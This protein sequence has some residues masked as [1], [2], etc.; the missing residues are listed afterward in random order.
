M[1]KSPKAVDRLDINFCTAEH[2]QRRLALEKRRA[3]RIN[4]NFSIILLDLPEPAN[5]NG[6]LG[7]LAKLICQEIRETDSV[8][9]HPQGALFILLPDT[10]HIGASCVWERLQI[11]L[12]AR[13]DHQNNGHG[14]NVFS[15]E[16]LCY[17]EKF[18]EDKLSPA[19]FA[20]SLQAEKKNGNGLHH[21]LLPSAN[22]NGHY[23][24]ISES[25]GNGGSLALPISA[26]LELDWQ[27]PSD[28]WLKAKKILKR[29]MDIFGA[30]IG[31]ILFSPFM[32]LAALLIKLTSAGPILF[33]QTRLGYQGKHFGFLKFRSMYHNCDERRHQDYV[34]HLIHGK[35]EAV[36]HGSKEKPLYKIK[37]DGRITPLGKFLRKTSLDELPQLWN[38]LKGDM[39]LVGPRPPIP[40]EV[41]EYQ[42]WHRRRILEVKPGITG[43]WQVSGRSQTTFDEM[44][45]LD[46]HYAKNWSL[47]LDIK[48]LLKTVKV[49]FLANG[50]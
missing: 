45:R 31:L 2:F 36:N 30:V 26:A 38:V 17:P 14:R 34:R 19:L 9:S 25:A 15:M 4:Y 23:P 1:L 44:V 37:D 29:G 21:V 8:C 12:A 33:R 41:E 24:M 13:E 6:E 28:S 42:N 40:Y 43:L 27:L 50:T 16:I 49:L 39:S 18:A 11:K 7:K 48:I 20:G 5:G 35:N 10:D 46:L 3:E 22:G 32:L 47:G